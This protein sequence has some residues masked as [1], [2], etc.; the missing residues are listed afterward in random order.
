MM[1]ISGHEG[2]VVVQGSGSNQD[3]QVRNEVPLLAEG[4]PDPGNDK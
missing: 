3:G 4:C 2:Q 1:Q